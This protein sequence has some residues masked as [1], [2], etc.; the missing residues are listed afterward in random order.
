MFFG[1]FPAVRA[2]QS[3]TF[4]TSKEGSS[5]HRFSAWC[6]VVA[7]LVAAPSVALAQASIAGVFVINSGAILP[8]WTVEAASPALI[9][10]VARR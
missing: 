10:K 6:L 1:E 4:S 9:E 2:L 7:V 5:M 8:G 3:A